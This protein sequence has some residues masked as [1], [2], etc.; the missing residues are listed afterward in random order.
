MGCCR[1]IG[2]IVTLQSK[3][4]GVEPSFQIEEK[5]K[6]KGIK[7]LMSWA[8]NWHLVERKPAITALLNVYLVVLDFFLSSCLAV[9]LAFS[10][11]L[12]S[13]SFYR[14]NKLYMHIIYSAELN[15][16]VYAHDISCWLGIH[17]LMFFTIT[18]SN[19][20]RLLTS[21]CWS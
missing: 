6:R 10:L 21:T 14:K 8:N 3:S 7:L 12:A 4:S 17:S 13:F 5:K 19:S 16:S 11:L 1:L 20:V 15:H 18:I 9:F 2:A